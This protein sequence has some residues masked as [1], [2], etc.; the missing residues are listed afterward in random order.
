MKKFKEIRVDRSRKRQANCYELGKAFVAITAIAAITTTAT[1]KFFGW[2]AKV[3]FLKLHLTKQL[4]I[5]F[6]FPAESSRA[7]G[8]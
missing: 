3:L 4:H 7:L 5:L 8:L 2:V 1:M 6:V